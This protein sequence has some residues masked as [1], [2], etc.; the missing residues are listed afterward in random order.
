MP[1]Q[2][3]RSVRPLPFLPVVSSALWGAEQA[4]SGSA[5]RHTSLGQSP[6]PEGCSSGWYS[7]WGGGGRRRRWGG[8][9]N[10]VVATVDAL[11]ERKSVWN[12]TDGISILTAPLKGAVSRATHSE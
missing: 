6:K 9:D 1:E 5:Q 3:Q 8:G 10:Q 12:W 7:L 2:L 11:Q 4:L